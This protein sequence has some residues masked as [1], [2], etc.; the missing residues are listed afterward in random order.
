[1]LSLSSTLCVIGVI[2]VQT[3]ENDI[4]TLPISLQNT[5][6]LRSQVFIP[7]LFMG[8]NGSLYFQQQRDKQQILGYIP[9]FAFINNDF[10]YLKELTNWE[11]KNGDKLTGHVLNSQCICKY[12]HYFQKSFIP[13]HRIVKI[14]KH[15][16]SLKWMKNGTKPDLCLQESS[17]GIR[18]LCMYKVLSIA[19]TT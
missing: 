5:F 9:L 13:P 15:I 19:F 1:M 16:L 8:S 7:I 4:Q 18:C 17:K 6:F 11:L 12:L 2:A 14:T 10:Q 3:N